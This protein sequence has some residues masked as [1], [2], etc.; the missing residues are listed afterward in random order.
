MDWLASARASGELNSP[1]RRIGPGRLA[2][3]GAVGLVVVVGAVWVVRLPI[4]E[5]VLKQQ[6]SAPGA[7]AALKMT[8]LDFGGATIQDVRLGRVA[9]PDFSAKS[10]AASFRWRWLTSEVS[11]LSVDQARLKI[12]IGSKGVSLGVLDRWFRHGP[13]GPPLAP[14]LPNLVIEAR[15]AGLEIDTPLG[16]FLARGQAQGSLRRDF[17]MELGV[18]P[19]NARGPDGALSAFAAQ[20][21]ARTQGGRLAGKVDVTAQRAEWRD[22][23]LVQPAFHAALSVPVDLT[24]ATGDLDLRIG[25]GAIGEAPFAE[26][27][28]QAHV[29]GQALGPGWWPKIWT[30]QA[31]AQLAGLTGKQL[32]A[33]AL[34]AD[35]GLSGEAGN[36]TG[37]LV[38]TLDRGGA[39]GV[40]LAGAR[41]EGPFSTA[42][43]RNPIQF[44]A[45][46]ELRVEQASVDSPTRARVLAALPPLG[47]TPLGPLAE[48]S[49]AGLNRAM[50]RFTLRA[51]LTLNWEGGGGRLSTPGPVSLTAPNDARVEIEPPSQTR[52]ALAIDLPSGAIEGEAGVAMGGGGLPQATLAVESLKVKDG[53]LALDGALEIVN[54]RTEGAAARSG[55][56]K[57]ALRNDAKGGSATVEG[58]ALLT[59]P[60]A[61]MN[62]VDADVPL[63][64]R[65]NWSEGFSVSAQGARCIPVKVRRLEVAGLAFTNAALPLCPITSDAFATG[66]AAGVL[67]GGFAIDRL[68]LAGVMAD[69]PRPARLTL[70]GVRGELG[71]KASAMTLAT[72]ISAPELAIDWDQARR[73]NL[74]SKSVTANLRTD[75]KGWG[76]TGALSD[77]WITD[78]TARARVEAFNASWRADPAK[79]DVVIR[80]ERGAGRVFDPHE[81]PLIAPLRL[82]DV[83]VT[84]ADGVARG[85]GGIVTEKTGAV[86]GNFELT[87]ALATG[88]GRA[89]VHAR[90]LT[91]SPEL[92]PYDVAPPFLGIIDNVAGPVDGDI[93][94]AWS[95]ET[96][97]TAADVT[98]KKLNLATAALG[99]VEGVDGAMHF[100]DFAQLTTSPGQVLRVGM[101]NPGIPVRDGVV[102][103]QILPN[104]DVKIESAEWPFSGGTLSIAPTTVA[105]IGEETRMTLA[106]ANV[107]VAK[108]TQEMNIKGLSAT[109]Q[110]EGRFPL[111]FTKL[112]G[113]IEQGEL[114][115]TPPGGVIA[116]DGGFDQ[117]GGPAQLAFGALRA[118]RYESLSLTLDGDLGGELVTKIAFQGVNR[119]PVKPVGGPAPISL[120]GIPFK[121][122]VTVQAPFMALA[123]NAAG[124][125]DPRSLLEQ[126]RPAIS[127]TATPAETPTE[128]PP[129]SP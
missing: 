19:T 75:A 12:T 74:K 77:V 76:V 37:N 125:S 1:P 11:A 27:R 10:I 50:Q 24:S 71:G 49:Q 91:F 31:S 129:K 89:V 16:A 48:A 46:S 26:A 40:V 124:F 93:T 44:A 32:S 113:R 78:S 118:F 102:R 69:A 121:F 17:V 41:L 107:D 86:I 25:G 54:W 128:T 115:A 95:G 58:Q 35:V 45:R 127:V 112:T 83:A 123:R 117:G 106:L 59:G 109:G 105:F 94:A 15:D 99:P 97:T 4:A 38:T 100:N 72:T 66:D 64:L 47:A 63:N 14:T 73:I 13:V 92:Q 84:L 9:R 79:D 85:Q 3:F 8:R 122:N 36:V 80:M 103:F 82:S 20:V 60:F 7:P 90:D 21:S 96:F 22:G 5:L 30:G 53:A 62:L 88:E 120:V 51:P 33:N 6:F 23:A 101:I 18:A 81:K 28:V 65:A 111:V 70:A 34:K 56:I 52:A 61:G 68:A 98:L 57:V 104:L 119:E 126:A 67:S 110:V 42:L 2:T 108:L 116:Y 55:P 29:D 43:S 87:H 39:F 114:R